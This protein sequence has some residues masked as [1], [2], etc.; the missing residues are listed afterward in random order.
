MIDKECGRP[1]VF[2][3]GVW[4]AAQYQ[5]VHLRAYACNI[6]VG[7]H[8]TRYLRVCNQCRTRPTLNLQTP[9]RVYFESIHS[10]ALAA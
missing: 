3:K 1:N 2:M 9:V 8:L 6:D 10:A 7:D 4:R 5:E